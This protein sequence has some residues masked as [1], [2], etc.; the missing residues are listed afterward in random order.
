MFPFLVNNFEYPLSG[1]VIQDIS[2]FFSMQQ[3]VPEIEQEIV[4]HVAS[5]G[6]QLG[7]LTDAVL[8]LAKACKV[9]GEEIAEVQRIAKEVEDAKVRM[10]G[11]LKTRAAA[12]LARLKEADEGGWEDLT[13]R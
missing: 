9:D 4:R 10:K 8:V 13:N 11:V 6:D 5:Y 12:A 1:D 3:G 2:P 7:A